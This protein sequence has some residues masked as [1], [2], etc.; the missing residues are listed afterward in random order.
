MPSS[1]RGIDKI[2]KR[3]STIL[4]LTEQL[5]NRTAVA[6]TDNATQKVEQVKDVRLAGDGMK[7]KPDAANR[8]SDQGRADDEAG[9]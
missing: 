8:N 4:S 9:E 6:K 7:R 2:I 1:I 3:R 5:V